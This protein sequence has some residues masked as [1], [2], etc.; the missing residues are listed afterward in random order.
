MLYIYERR[1][2]C[3]SI[4]DV[5]KEDGVCRM[6]PPDQSVPVWWT[7]DCSECAHW[8]P[9][10]GLAADHHLGWRPLQHVLALGCSLT[11]PASAWIF[12]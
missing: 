7:D 2:V 3:S 4:A 6:N 12:Q 10:S 9:A 11:L 5:L 8:S 1:Y